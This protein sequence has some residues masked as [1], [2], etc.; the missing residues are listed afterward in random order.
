LVPLV[1]APPLEVGHP[2]LMRMRMKPKRPTA[3]ANPGIGSGCTHICKVMCSCACGRFGS[4]PG[5]SLDSKTGSRPPGTLSWRPKILC[6]GSKTGSRQ[7]G[8][9]SW[10]SKTGSRRTGTL[11]WSSQ[12]V[13]QR[14][15]TPSWRPKP[16]SG[17]RLG[18]GGERCAW[19]GIH[20]LVVRWVLGSPPTPA[21]YMTSRRWL[22]GGWVLG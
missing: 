20:G 19:M 11:S 16:P 14:A 1:P 18:G 3:S 12:T 8:I 9:L 6:W 5:W 10:S 2:M 7:A 21:H 17:G 15:E 13:S 4:P 22:V